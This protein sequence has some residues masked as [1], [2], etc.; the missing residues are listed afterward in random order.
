MHE[1]VRGWRVVIQDI[2]IINQTTNIIN[3]F[4][5][6]IVGGDYH[7]SRPSAAGS[8]VLGGSSSKGLHSSLIRMLLWPI[9]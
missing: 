1:L 5:K 4:V 9:G 3:P 6:F 8:V 7:V 2:E